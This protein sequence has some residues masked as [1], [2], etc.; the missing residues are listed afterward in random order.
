MTLCTTIIFALFIY[1]VTA[2]N[3]VP[4]PSFEEQVRC[5]QYPDIKT[6]DNQV[7]AEFPPIF[8]FNPTYSTPDY[9]SQCA[10]G[11]IGIP[12]NQLG[13]QFAH[14]G[15]SYIGI[16]PYHRI[17]GIESEYREYMQCK[18][19]SPLQFGMKYRVSMWVSLADKSQYSINNL[20]FYLSVNR[21]TSTN[22][23]FAIDNQI[24][25]KTIIDRTQEWVEIT[26]F[27][28]ADSS[29]EWLTIGNFRPLG[30]I[31]YKQNSFDS[32]GNSASAYYYIDDVIVELVNEDSVLH[33][34]IS[35]TFTPNSD[36][37]NDIW[38]GIALKN[39]SSIQIYN[40]W[41]IQIFSGPG[42]W[43]GNVNGAEATEG[44]YFYV[45]T[46]PGGER[47]S[48]TVTLLR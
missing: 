24:Y 5:P 35:N 31:L 45:L 6:W 26:G 16:Y 38:P 47:R 3:L 42:S 17:G 8:W 15:T 22:S 29:V 7:F 14:S 12:E 19:K 4:N 46:Q 1:S 34:P 28:T 18:L 21:P 40:R 36:G 11:S 48:G 44:V 23:F 25:S 43:D 27:W 9:L 20:G 32:L 37:V 33:Y 2:Q 39:T 41:G 30:D 13:F 10:L